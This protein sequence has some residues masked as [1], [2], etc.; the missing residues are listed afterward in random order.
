[1]A[2]LEFHKGM[3]THFGIRNA[4]RFLDPFFLRLGKNKLDILKFDDW[5]HA[6]FGEYD[7]EGTNTSMKDL[8][9][10]KFGAD[11]VAFCLKAM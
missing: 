7:A 10:N 8:I 2:I 11:A 5:L 3:K 1:M 9:A 4:G 6:Q